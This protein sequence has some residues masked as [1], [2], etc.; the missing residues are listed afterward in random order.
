MS[1]TSQERWSLVA[2]ILIFA[3][4]PSLLAEVLCPYELCDCTN[5]SIDCK[6]QGFDKM[7]PLKPGKDYPQRRLYVRGNNISVIND[8]ELVPNLQDITLEEDSLTTIA[9]HAFIYSAKSLQKL[10]FW[11]TNLTSLPWALMDLSSLEELSWYNSP[12]LTWNTTILASIGASLKTLRLSYLTMPNFPSDWLKLLVKLDTLEIDTVTFGQLSSKPLDPS[13]S[14]LKHLAIWDSNLTK[15][16][17]EVV[18]LIPCLTSLDLASNSISD[19]NNLKDLKVR[20]NLSELRLDSNH[21]DNIGPLFYLTGIERLQISNNRICDY[22][23]IPHALIPSENSLRYLSLSSNCLTQIPDLLFMSE[24]REL[25]LDYNNIS[26]P[27]SGVLPT[28]LTYLYLEENV[29]TTIPESISKMSN[30]NTLY[31]SNN[32]IKSMADFEFPTSLAYLHISDNDIEVIPSL[33]FSNNISK[34]TTMDLSGNP[35][36]TIADDAFRNLHE[37]SYLN[38]RYTPLVRL[39]PAL[40]TLNK[41]HTL[42]LPDTLTCSCDDMAFT[43]WYQNLTN[44]YGKCNGTDLSLMLHQLPSQCPVS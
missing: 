26:T 9:D 14:H 30:L 27:S 35:I 39:P 11:L 10:E 20:L 34:L 40:L 25:Y 5:D 12:V 24:L 3:W 42:S 21:I 6:Y 43:T 19:L 22:K 36:K 2:W 31:L 16:P 29:M 37:L 13:A 4:A 18:V 15:I 23:H 17:E 41:L 44:L 28:S 32:K 38:L 7:P 33:Q 8:C 1:G